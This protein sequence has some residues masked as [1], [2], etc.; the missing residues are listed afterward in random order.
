[1]YLSGHIVGLSYLGF[2]PPAVIP[3]AFDKIT[4]YGQQ[5]VDFTWVKNVVLSD[6]EIESILINNTP[7]WDSDT[8]LLANFDN[9]LNAGNIVNLSSPIVK[10][11]I[12]RQDESESLRQT[13]ASLPNTTSQYFD[14]TVAGN[15]EYQY[16]IFPITSTETGEP[17]ATEN[18]ST[19]FYNWSLTDPITNTVFLFD[20][21]LESGDI[22]NEID[23]T[24]YQTYT[25]YNKISRGV[26]D[27]IRGS[28]NCI[29]GYINVNGEYQSPISYISELKSVINNGNVKYLKSRKGDIW[30]VDTYGF[31]YKYMDDIKDQPQQISFEFTEIAEVV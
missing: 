28:V 27:F 24:E 23:R 20:L 6:A 30:A 31:K 26:R 16:F 12:Q 4:I 2:V 8:I 21:N 10:W 7:V 9:S 29:A 13:V 17:L 18:I 11:V 19:N 25:K 22:S 5:T 14:Y 1:M 3:T 15:K